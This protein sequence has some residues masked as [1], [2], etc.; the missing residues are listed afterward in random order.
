MAHELRQRG[1]DDETV[2]QAV[3][4]LD[5][6]DELAAARELVRRRLAATRGEDPQRRV[7]RLAGMLA[8]KGYGAGL[9]HQV[10]REALGAEVIESMADEGIL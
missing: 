10:I 2:Q 8:R 3:D 9:S 4:Q 6:D 5:R 1:V 7:R